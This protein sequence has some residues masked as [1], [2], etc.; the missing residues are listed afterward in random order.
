M[1]SKQGRQGIER[2]GSKGMSSFPGQIRIAQAMPDNGCEVAPIGPKYFCLA[3]K[4]A[5]SIEYRHTKM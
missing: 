1:P 4:Y 5:R 2:V 3:P